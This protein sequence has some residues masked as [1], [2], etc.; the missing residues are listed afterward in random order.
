MY[1]HLSLSLCIYILYAY[2]HR[3][4]HTCQRSQ[5]DTSCYTHVR[6]CMYIYIYIYIYTYIHTYMHTYNGPWAKWCM[7]SAYVPYACSLQTYMWSQPSHC[8]IFLV[9]YA[10]ILTRMHAAYGCSSNIPHYV[11]YFGS[12]AWVG[13][14]CDVSYEEG[15]GTCIYMCVYCVCM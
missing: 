4:C 7:C 3:L 10:Y 1:V 9:T 13:T 14:Q 11:S 8:D 5:K 15:I 6:V 12:L 2:I